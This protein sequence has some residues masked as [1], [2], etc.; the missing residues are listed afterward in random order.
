MIDPNNIIK[1]NRSD[2]ELQELLLFLIAVAGKT[3]SQV[4]PRLHKF[5]YRLGLDILVNQTPFEIINMFLQYGS[6]VERLKNHG[7]GCYTRLDRGF[8]E[9]AN[10]GLDL[11]TCTKEDLMQIHG[12]GR[13]S[14][15]CFLAWTRRGE[16]VAMLDTHLLKYLR[17]WQT[18]YAYYPKGHPEY[19]ALSASTLLHDIAI[20]KSTPSSKKMYDRLEQAYLKICETLHKDPVEYDLEIWRYYANKLDKVA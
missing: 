14:A 7:F 11:R 16:R 2:K 10:C 12:V 9:A 5:L 18:T 17:Y 3:A 6:M 20:P 1:F 4:A 13:K 8:K 15:S 19:N